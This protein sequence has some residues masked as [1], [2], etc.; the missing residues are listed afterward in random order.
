M[1]A[2]SLSKMVII[3]HHRD[4]EDAEDAEIIDE[5][6]TFKLYYFFGK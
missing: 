6:F 1:P 3:I 2:R 4:A 5:I